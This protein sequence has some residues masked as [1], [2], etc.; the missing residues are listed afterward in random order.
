MRPGAS[1]RR[2]R[3]AGTTLAEMMTVVAIIGMLSAMGGSALMDMVVAD[4]VIS[5]SK[6]LM[7]ALGGARIRA[8]SSNCP[9]YVQVNGPT[10][11][12][13]GAAGFVTQP[14]LIAVMRK[15]NCASTV[16]RFEPG[17]RAVDSVALG[18]EEVP[19]A[20]RLLLPTAVLSSQTLTNQ[21][22]VF[23][24]DRLGARFVSVDAAGSGASGFADIT[25]V[26]SVAVNLTLQENAGTPKHPLVV[27]L[28]IA[29][30]AR[31]Q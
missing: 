14:S 6:S 1:G 25:A 17:D 23:A 10:Y 3:P 11:A 9:H 18:P 30:A 2:R 16:M 7:G 5:T 22:V 27:V 15:S 29:G 8:A 13:T 20:V 19:G 26:D 28:P 4:R 24:F 12:G 21:S 31:L